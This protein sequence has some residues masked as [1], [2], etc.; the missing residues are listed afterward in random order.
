MILGKISR[1]L[2][3][4]VKVMAVRNLPRLNRFLEDRLQLHLLRRHYYS[5]IPDPDDLEPG[6]LSLIHI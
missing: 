6:Y 2:S 4:P 3:S 1:R 5:P